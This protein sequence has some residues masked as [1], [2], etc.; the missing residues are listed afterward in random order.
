MAG[1]YSSS[2]PC[3]HRRAAKLGT[4]ILAQGAALAAQVSSVREELLP[5]REEVREIR[6]LLPLRE[7]VRELLPLRELLPE[8][9]AT[10]GVAKGGAALQY[11]LLPYPRRAKR[12]CM[13][14]TLH[15][16]T[17]RALGTAYDCVAAHAPARAAK[18]RGGARGA[19]CARGRGRL[20]AGVRGDG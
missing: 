13:L 4:T 7:E 6:E 14:H 16:A 19:P 2:G 8:R 10:G 15:G 11:H 1:G 17:F 18:G 3:L 12:V 9:I 5:L 20:C